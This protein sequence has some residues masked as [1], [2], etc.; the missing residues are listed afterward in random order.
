M[1]AADFVKPLLREIGTVHFSR[2]N[3]KPGKPTTFASFNSNNGAYNKTTLFFGLPGNPVSCLVTKSLFVDPA[4]K[5][6][7]GLDSEACLHP[8][9]VIFYFF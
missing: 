2:L 9:M 7:Q 5:R 8:Q 1:G 3:M 4:L 6:M